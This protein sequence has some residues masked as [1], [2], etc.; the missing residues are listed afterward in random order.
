[1]KPVYPIFYVLIYL[2][3]STSLNAQNIVSN[4]APRFERSSYLT[5][6][7]KQSNGKVIISGAVNY[8]DGHYVSNIARLNEDGTLDQSFNAGTGAAGKYSRIEVVEVLDDGKILVGG[9]FTHFNDEPFNNLV[10]LNSDGSID[11]SFD[12]GNGFD[13]TVQDVYALP[14]GA[15][16]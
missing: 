12:I 3:L 2:I 16:N 6:L 15:A 9:T 7:A 13:D 14:N 4:F 11:Y 5:Y 1:M 10:R 8:V